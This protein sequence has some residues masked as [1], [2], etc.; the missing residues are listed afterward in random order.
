MFVNERKPGCDPEMPWSRV[1]KWAKIVIIIVSPVL[2]ISWDGT[3]VALH[4]SCR[5]HLLLC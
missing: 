1:I 3:P 5:L 4:T 2:Q